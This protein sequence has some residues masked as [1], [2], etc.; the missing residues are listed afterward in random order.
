MKG[1]L[2][3]LACTLLSLYTS[4]QPLHPEASVPLYEHLCEINQQ[5]LKMAPPDAALLADEAFATDEQRIQRHLQL[6]EARLR[7]QEPMALTAEQQANRSQL[8]DTLRAYW[9]AGRFPQ[10]TRHPNRQPYF[11]DD[12][13]TACAVGYL[14]LSSG[15]AE[16]VGRIRQAD[17]YAYLHDLLPVYPE[18]GQWADAHGFAVDEL[19]WIQPAYFNFDHQPRPVGQDQG[20]D[21]QVNAM[22]AADD[23]L[24]FGG[25]FS[26][27]AGFEAANI[28]AYDGEDI[29]REMPG[30][31]GEVRS[32]A[33]VAGSDE[34]VAVGDFAFDG[35]TEAVQAAH[36]NGQAW[37]PL[38]S[39]F[40]GE[41]KGVRCT[42][43]HCYF[44][45]AFEHELGQSLVAYS[46]EAGEWQAFWPGRELTGEVNSIDLS[47][48][49]LLV[50]G[51]FVLREGMDT[52]AQQIFML[53]LGT[54][55]LLEISHTEVISSNT[56]FATTLSIKRVMAVSLLP[57]A[58]GICIVW[59]EVEANEEDY[60][61]FGW[62]SKDW[63]NELSWWFEGVP[64]EWGMANDSWVYGTLGTPPLL[65][66]YFERASEFDQPQVLIGLFPSFG[67]ITMPIAFGDGPVRAAAEFQGELFVAGDFSELGGQAI[68]GLARGTLDLVSSA[69]EE[70][71]ASAAMSV[72]AHGRQLWLDELP[73]GEPGLI[74]LFDLSGRTVWQRQ[75]SG[76]ASE[77]AIEL[78]RQLPNGIYAY[79]LSFGQDMA[80]GK[81]ALFVP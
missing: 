43:E 52:L 31:N 7:E 69:G 26:T 32:L 40:S 72:R 44:Y 24:Y 6:V 36:W 46:L 51:Q 74:E 41:L 12:R 57:A 59:A 15:E 78:D 71:T 50:G 5:W 79:R 35:Q 39:N 55:S 9:Q 70:D 63:N 19:A 33:V 1:L 22:A 42:E 67:I 62:Y 53:E 66:G 8:L 18:L 20:V 25:Q 81:L 68:N 28:A 49:T 64:G 11:V 21:G 29:W 16:L 17:N 3:L 60:F 2:T 61:Y 73:T 65:Y 23:W 37:Q 45:G 27:I 77:L 10:N 30:L 75:L 54:E 34:V 38:P 58:D 76:G 56:P 13:S 47:G 4:G 14:L 80:A 48:D